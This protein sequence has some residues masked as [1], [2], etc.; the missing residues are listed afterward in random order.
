[1]LLAAI[2]ESERNYRDAM[3]IYR[4]VY[5]ECPRGTHLPW[6]ARLKMGELAKKTT[7]DESR[8]TIFSEVILAPHPFA[9]SRLKARF[10]SGEITEPQLTAHWIRL[11]PASRAYLHLIA[12]KALMNGEPAVARVYL[13]EYR[14]HLH[15]STWEHAR[16]Q[17][18]LNEISGY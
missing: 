16:I 7:I 11:Y 6:D 13:Q 8:E 15:H 2:Y 1:M 5:R 17:R 12:R 10:F 4:K 14:Q 3:T 9:R 18:L